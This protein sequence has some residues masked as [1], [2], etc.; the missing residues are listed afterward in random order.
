MT[1]ED[2]RR[3]LSLKDTRGKH[4]I[5]IS[6]LL[7]PGRRSFIWKLSTARVQRTNFYHNLL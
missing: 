5:W 3:N 2:I 6:T 4:I 1:L 7:A